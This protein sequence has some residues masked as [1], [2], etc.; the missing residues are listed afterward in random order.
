MEIAPRRTGAYS[1]AMSVWE[2]PPDRAADAVEVLLKVFPDFPGSRRLGEVEERR[3]ASLIHERTV[4]S[5]LAIGRIN[6]WGDPP[7]GVAVWLRRPAL[8]EPEPRPPRP[9]LGALLPP[10]VV[11]ALERFDATMQR[12]RALARPDAHVYLDMIG[13]L[14]SHRRQ[15]IATALMEA[16]HLWTDHLGLPAALDTDTEENVSFYARRGYAV[17]ARERLP[18]SDRELVAMRRPPPGD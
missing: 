1:S 12:L 13:V 17:M 14:P 4:E 15:G 5:G 11:N 3:I 6:V 7:V 16:G 18:D 2:L 9:R 10:E 8:D